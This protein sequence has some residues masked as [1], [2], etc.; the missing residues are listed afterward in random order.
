MQVSAKNCREGFLG[1]KWKRRENEKN[2]GEI[3]VAELTFYCLFIISMIS[4]GES[5]TFKSLI[6]FETFSSLL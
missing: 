1:T 5:E 6:W 4:L 2:L 3:T